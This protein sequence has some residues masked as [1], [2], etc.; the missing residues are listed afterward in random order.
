K[1]AKAELVSQRGCPK[2]PDSLWID[3][4]L[5]QFVDLDKIYTR[6]Y[7]LNPEYKHTEKV[8][9][10]EIV[11]NMGGSGSSVT[12]IIRTHRE[13]I[14]TFSSLKDTVLFTYP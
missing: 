14:I 3:I 8:G 13:W 7:L 10:V 2:F 6:V 1:G 9:D 5:N 4:L 11:L 12:K